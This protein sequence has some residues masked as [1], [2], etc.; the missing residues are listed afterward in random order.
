[1]RKRGNNEGSIYRD[2][3]GYWRGSVTLYSEHGKQKKKYF[4]GRTKKEVSDKVSRTLNEIRNHTYIEPTAMTLGEWLRIWLDTYCRNMLRPST[5]VNYDIYIEKH[6]TPTI[7]SIRLYELNAVV[8]QQFYNDKL[9]NGKLRTKGGLK[10]KTLRNLHNMLHKALGQAYRMEMIPK[11][12]AD[13]VTIPRQEKKERRF[14]TVDEQKQLQKHLKDD[15]IGM[16]I[17]LDLYTGMR[18]GELLGLMWKD[19]HIDNETGC[20]LRV[21]QALNRN[22]NYSKKKVGQTLLEIGYPK[23]PHSIRNIP[24]LPEIVYKLRV[25]REK[26]AEYCRSRGIVQNGYVFTNSAGNWIDP[27]DFQRD[28]KLTLKRCGIREINVHGIRHTFATRSL[29]SG[30]SA[31]ALSKI[32]GHANVGFTLDTY[33][34]VTDDLMIDEMSHLQEFL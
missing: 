22:K 19:V 10:P 4:C 33:A 9:K 23:T 3:N 7:G 6:I 24:L 13:F 26:Q 17:L 30:M 1:M 25:Y 12:P 2:K 11:N 18:Q 28:F 29:E 16:A 8:L 20:F 31:K 34:H 32:L 21:T 14:L 27:R 15:T 5:L